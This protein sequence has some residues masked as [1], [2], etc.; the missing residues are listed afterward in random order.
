MD[1]SNEF[2][3]DFISQN[4]H[5]V[6]S[7]VA[8]NGKPESALVGIAATPEL[9]LIFDTVTSSRK[10]V[11]LMQNPNIALVIG[12]DHER[13]IQ[14]EGTIF[15]PDTAQLTQLQE[16]YFSV[17]PDGRERLKSWKDIA[18]FCIQ[19]KWIRYSD[20][21]APSIIKEKYY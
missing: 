16:V 17:F 7:T 19:P 21:N 2:L 8:Q 1:L 12:W 13:T 15:Q 6:V 20:F 3:Y 14:Y 18:Y 4:K 11:N 10:Y 9:V 5:A